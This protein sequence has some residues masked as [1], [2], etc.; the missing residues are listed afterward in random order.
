MTV[1]LGARG[2]GLKNN[3]KRKELGMNAMNFFY[4]NTRK[5]VT[6]ALFIALLL[7]CGAAQAGI[8]VTVAGPAGSVKTVPGDGG[9]FNV[10]LPLAKNSVNNIVV[11]AQDDAG[12]S[13][14]E[15]WPLRS[16]LWI[17]LSSHRC[18][19]SA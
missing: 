5:A 17:R 13:A 18:T 14:S 7:C 11:T 1:R 8:S 12:N 19:P 16:F 3:D 9:V 10:N 2:V 4:A 15:N 6:C